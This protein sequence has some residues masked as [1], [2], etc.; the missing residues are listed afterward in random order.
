MENQSELLH[1]DPNILKKKEYTG[2]LSNRVDELG[3]EG[4][5]Q[6]LLT[7]HCESCKEQT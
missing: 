7:K 2:A 4:K 6:Q 5:H 3:D 1:K